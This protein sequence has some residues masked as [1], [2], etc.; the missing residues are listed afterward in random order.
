MKRRVLRE[1]VELPCP[2]CGGEC[3]LKCVPFKEE[4]L[5]EYWWIGCEI[6]G[7]R[8]L[9]GCGIGHSAVTSDDAV[10]KWNTRAAPEREW[11]PIETLLREM[12]NPPLILE[13]DS[14]IDVASWF[15]TKARA[16]L[17]AVEDNQLQEEK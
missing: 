17:A 11:Q 10:E 7:T 15:V 14:A 12:L 5:G 4:T 8:E 9:K 1:S 3:T 2:F 16:A 13:G 6:R